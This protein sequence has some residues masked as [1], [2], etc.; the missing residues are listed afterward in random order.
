MANK[1]QWDGNKKGLPSEQHHSIGAP[2][3]SR[4]I[5]RVITQQP[6]LAGA[7]DMGAILEQP[8][9][10]CSAAQHSAMQLAGSVMITPVRHLNDPSC[11]T[12]CDGRNGW[13][14]LCVALHPEFRWVVKQVWHHLQEASQCDR[15]AMVW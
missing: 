4:T 3:S 1:R 2:A 11:R 6:D 8:V 5:F 10:I 15:P 13:V 9:M 14:Q 12:R 7:G